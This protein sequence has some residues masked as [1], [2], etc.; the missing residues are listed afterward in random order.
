MESRQ[1]KVAVVGSGLMG[2][3][4]AACL[5]AG[6]GHEVYL[7]D[8]KDDALQKGLQKAKELA[9]FINDNGIP[10][11]PPSGCGAIHAAPSLAEAVDGASFVFEAVFEDLSIKQ[12]VFRQIERAL[13]GKEAGEE[14]LLCTN[15]SSLSITEIAA[16]LDRPGRF[17][18]AHF[19]GPPHLVPLVEVCGGAK[20]DS[21]AVERVREFL[22]ASGKRP[23]VLQKEIQGFI[24]AR[25]QA[26]LT[27]ECT[28]LLQQG[29]ASAECLDAAVYN[30]F[31][32]RLNTIG[33]LQQADFAGVDLL[34]KTHSVM[35][36]QLGAMTSDK[37]AEDLANKGRCG[38]KTGAGYYD[39]NENTIQEVTSRRDKELLRRLKQDFSPPVTDQT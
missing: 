38:V 3:G 17:V 30:G 14:A 9:A 19:I 34:V 2:S 25:L 15:T 36:P 4:I 26:A 16:V 18:A 10:P 28:Y 33:P 39:W 32:R 27:R 20:T 5:A 31:G 21:S 12:G 35:W 37:M 23:V 13:V 6:G 22:Q 1:R 11:A 8:T 7:T 29:V 24:A